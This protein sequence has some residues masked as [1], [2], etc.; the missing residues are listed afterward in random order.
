MSSTLG[1]FRIVS[2][3]PHRLTVDENGIHSTMTSDRA[4]TMLIQHRESI[5]TQ[6]R[7]A[8]DRSWLD[9]QDSDFIRP[10]CSNAFVAN[11]MV[12]HKGNRAKIRYKV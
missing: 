4:S 8:W 3:T 9:I 5:T 10:L 1:Q 2:E 12:G 6:I 11:D 7:I